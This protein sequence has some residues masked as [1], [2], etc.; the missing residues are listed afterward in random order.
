MRVKLFDL[1]RIIDELFDDDWLYPWAPVRG[2]RS[3][4]R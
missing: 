3:A 4:S 2:G 1:Q